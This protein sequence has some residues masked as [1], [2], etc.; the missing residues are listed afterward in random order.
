[1]SKIVVFIVSVLVG[2]ILYMSKPSWLFPDAIKG[3]PLASLYVPGKSGHAGLLWILT[4]GSFSYG[5][6]STTGNSKTTGRGGLFCKT[7]LYRYNPVDKKVIS[8]QVDKYDDL[9]SHS[10]SLFLKD[11]DVWCISPQS[12]RIFRYN[13]HT[14]ERDLETASFCA[15]FSELSAGIGKIRVEEKPWRLNLQTTDGRDFV[16]KFS[17]DS[18]Y[19]KQSIESQKRQE[20]IRRRQMRIRENIN[21]S[22]SATRIMNLQQEKNSPSEVSSDFFL[23]KEQ[24]SDVR[25][26]LCILSGPAQNIAR[27]RFSSLQDT[28]RF[29]K[30]QLSQPLVMKQVFLEGALMY[31]DSEYAIVVH[32]DQVGKDADRIISCYDTKGKLRFMLEEH[33]LLKGMALSKDDSFSTWFFISHNM[34]ADIAGDVATLS[35]Q[36]NKRGGVIGVSLTTGQ[37]L[38]EFNN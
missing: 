4:D 16:Y 28:S 6:S 3:R 27:F 1:M 29:E 24:N 26:R 9:P 10:F 15:R 18:L 31:K 34:H 2:L 20:I 33:Q 35:L 23:V 14:G 11:D 21:Q 25:H 5:T 36:G 8:M 32:Q 38:W 19:S 17:K 22:K 7:R 13:S 30:N 37:R 12:F